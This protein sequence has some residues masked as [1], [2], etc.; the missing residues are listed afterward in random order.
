MGAVVSVVVGGAAGGSCGWL[1][2]A[3]GCLSPSVSPRFRVG[4]S[5]DGD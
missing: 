2:C 1:L 3:F 4:S 5:H